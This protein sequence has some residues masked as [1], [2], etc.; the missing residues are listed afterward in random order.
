[1]YDMGHVEDGV[2]QTKYGTGVWR[3]AISKVV[4]QPEDCPLSGNCDDKRF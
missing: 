3:H 4:L 1:M 2:G